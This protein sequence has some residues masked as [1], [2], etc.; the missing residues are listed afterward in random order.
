MASNSDVVTVER[1]IE[2]P[3]SKVFAGWT[4]VS[5]MRRWLAAEVQADARVNGSYQV[6]FHTSQGVHIVSG[7]YRELAP[8]R[9]IVASLNYAGPLALNDAAHA[10]LTVELFPNG[11]R[12]EIHLRH[13]GLDGWPANPGYQSFI[14]Q[15]AWSK[16]FSALEKALL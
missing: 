8:P 10:R 16:A 11:P 12:T 7:R 9:R 1:L 5:L 6:E 15:G 4:E 2:A 3:A 13:G 14:A